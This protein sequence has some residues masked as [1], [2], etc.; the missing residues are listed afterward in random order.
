VHGTLH[1][2]EGE[3][4]EPGG[5]GLGEAREDHVGGPRREAGMDGWQALLR[6][7]LRQPEATGGARTVA[8][9]SRGVAKG[10]SRLRRREVSSLVSRLLV[11]H[12][13]AAWEPSCV[14]SMDLTKCHLQYVS[15]LLVCGLHVD[16]P[17]RDVTT[18]YDQEVKI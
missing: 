5:A 1:R 16:V 15:N 14:L 11:H 12:P 17:Q 18:K 13:L 4:L 2:R 9:S 7:D 6:C 10:W 8:T 3:R